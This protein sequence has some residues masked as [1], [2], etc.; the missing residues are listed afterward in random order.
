MILLLVGSLI[1][2]LALGGLAW[3]LGLGQ[4]RIT[5]PAMACA[6]AEAMLPG[7]D[8]RTAIIGS[9]G[10]AALVHGADGSVAVLKRHGAHV[11]ARRVAADAVATT[12]EGWRVETGE[13][14]FGAVLVRR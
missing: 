4:T 6:E 10:E 11:A 9:D 2:V 12:P 1:A 14:L 7:F 3:L 13:A 5:D 8:A